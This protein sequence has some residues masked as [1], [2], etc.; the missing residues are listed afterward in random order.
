MVGLGGLA[1]WVT[2]LHYFGTTLLK[3]CRPLTYSVQHLSSDSYHFKDH[4]KTGLVYRRAPKIFNWFQVFFLFLSSFHLLFVV[5]TVNVSPNHTQSLSLSLSLSYTHTN[6]I[7]HNTLGR[8]P[9]EESS[10][11]R[12]DLYLT[13]HNTYKRQTTPAPARF[14]PA[15]PSSERKQS[16]PLDGA[17]VGIGCR[18]H[19][20]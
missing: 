15:V 11:R 14:K 12:R 16:H 1:R 18:I 2:L 10:T 4:F 20:R 5:Q 7:R 13:T 9:L 6:T 19:S 3:G 8:T 17:A